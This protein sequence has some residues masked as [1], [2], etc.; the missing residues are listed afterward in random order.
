MGEPSWGNRSL[1]GDS[2]AARETV[3]QLEVPE[4]EYGAHVALA[5]D[6]SWML[7]GTDEGIMSLLDNGD[8]KTETLKESLDGS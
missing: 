6:S 8:L 7:G 3:Q 2:D 5:H 4:Q 1:Q